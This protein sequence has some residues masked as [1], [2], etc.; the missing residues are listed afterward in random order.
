[1]IIAIQADKLESLK[2]TTD[3]TLFISAEL[4]KRQYRLFSYEPHTLYVLNSK[5]YATGRFFEAYY[6]NFNSSF[7]ITSQT[8]TL[9]LHDVKAILIRQDPPFNMDYITSLYILDLLPKDILILNNPAGLRYYSEKIIPL[10]YPHLAPPTMLIS[11]FSEVVIEFLKEHRQ[12]ILKPLYW[13]G[14]KHLELLNIDNIT[15]AERLVES[16]LEKHQHIILQKFFPE[17]K[18]GDK[19]IFIMN[20]EPV[21]ALKR[22]PKTGEYRANLASGGT[23]AATEI[24]DKELE[25]CKEIAPGLVE[26]G[27]FV[28]GVD[29]IAGHL[30][31]V[32][33]TSPTGFIAIDRLYGINLAAKY[34]EYIT[35]F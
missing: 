15:N 24:T 32:N 28:A 19:R 27:I 6:E 18:D 8:Q 10:H 7:K 21:A 12:L 13:F 30:I 23:A 2:T 14:G 9:C 34:A 22:I 17:I 35:H 11:A 31:E 33:I 3:T 26:N 1:M 25:I 29:V 20:G 16:V 4:H 5:I